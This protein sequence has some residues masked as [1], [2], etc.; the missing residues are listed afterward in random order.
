MILFEGEQMKSV[1]CRAWPASFLLLATF[2][3]FAEPR[4]FAEPLPLKRVVELALAHSTVTAAA[5]ADE[6]RVIAS[7]REARN[8]YIPQLVVGSGLGK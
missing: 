3:V 6:Q 2:V 4:L 5:N 1:F 8:Q 7:Y